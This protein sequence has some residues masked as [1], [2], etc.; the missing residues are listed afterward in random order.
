MAI[1]KRVTSGELLCA[2]CLFN[3]VV[4]Q[5]RKAINYYA[6][7]KRGSKV[8][9][10]IRFDRPLESLTAFKAFLK[11]SRKLDLEISILCIDINN[12]ICKNSLLQLFDV[13]DT[14]MEKIVVGTQYIPNGFVELIK[15]QEA[16]GLKIAHEIKKEVIVMPLFRDELTLLALIGILRLSKEAF[17]EHLPVKKNSQ[18]KIVRPFYYVISPDVLMLTYNNVLLRPLMESIEMPLT[19]TDVEYT[20]L[21]HAKNILW[22]STELIYSSA[23]SIEFLQSFMLGKG[24]KC[25]YCLGYSEDNICS[26][27]KSFANIV[28]SLEYHRV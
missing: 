16:I 23:K 11:A 25:S 17:G 9:F 26:Y 18:F 14:Q 10:I 4:T 2:H 19:Y 20:L 1:Y 24:K 22:S 28:D 13:S 7:F 3:S 21:K 8:L 27:C 6:M 12:S 5:V 15:F